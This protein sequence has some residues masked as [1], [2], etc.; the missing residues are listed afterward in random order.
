M[1]CTKRNIQWEKNAKNPICE[2][3]K[4]FVRTSFRQRNNNSSIQWHFPHQPR[5]QGLLSSRPPR[6]TQRR[7]RK[8]ERP[9]ERVCSYTASHQNRASEKVMLEIHIQLMA[10]I[11]ANLL[12]NN[13][14]SMSTFT[15]CSNLSTFQFYPHSPVA[16]HSFSH[17]FL[18]YQSFL[19]LVPFEVV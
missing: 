4:S 3:I 16:C 8:D 9:W 13:K 2:W 19:S 17:I 5:S 6:V 1:Q 14:D 10:H 18:Q 12:W 15:I 11:R 7:G